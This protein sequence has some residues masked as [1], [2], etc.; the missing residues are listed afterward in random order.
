MLRWWGRRARMRR[1]VSR[2][3][4]PGMSSSR[5]ITAGSSA[6]TR[7]RASEPLAASP[8]TTSPSLAVRT[9]RRTSARMSSMSSTTST[10]IC[11]PF[12]PTAASGTDPGLDVDDAG[13]GVAPEPS[14]ESSLARRQRTPRRGGPGGAAGGRPPRAQGR[15]RGAAP[16]RRRRGRLRGSS[17]R[18]GARRR[19]QRQPYG[20]G[21]APAL[22]ALGPDPTVMGL[23]DLPAD[24]EAQPA[25]LD[26]G[27]PPPDEA[28]EDPVQL[29]GR[30]AGPFVAH[31][32][33]DGVL[34]QP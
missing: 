3:P 17:G 25:A 20:E 12:P 11:T 7:S 31:V 30:E 14:V 1:A 28:I 22:G 9:T 24:V 33:D 19:H 32:H 8:A 18:S 10:G 15:A 29:A 2:P 26:A 16:G 6:S 34:L 27:A 5:T 13:R 4:R 23:D 21:G